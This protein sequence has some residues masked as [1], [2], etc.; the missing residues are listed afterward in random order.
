[1]TVRG[2]VTGSAALRTVLRFRA[3]DSQHER[4]HPTRRKRGAYPAADGFAEAVDPVEE[5]KIE[6]E[7]MRPDGPEA[8]GC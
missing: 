2:G 4:H 6:P 8:E 7:E 3:P 5:M 1:M